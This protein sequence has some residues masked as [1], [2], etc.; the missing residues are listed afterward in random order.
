MKGK[1]PFFL[2]KFTA[3]CIAVFLLSEGSL[4]SANVAFD[5]STYIFG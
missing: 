1:I 3:L 2:K 4:V 5:Q